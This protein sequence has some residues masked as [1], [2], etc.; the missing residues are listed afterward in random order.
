MVFTTKTYLGLISDHIPSFAFPLQIFCEISPIWIHEIQSVYLGNVPS[1]L[2][3]SFSELFW[4]MSLFLALWPNFEITTSHD[5]HGFKK[6]FSITLYCEELGSKKVAF[7]TFHSWRSVLTVK[8]VASKLVSGPPR[9]HF[10]PLVLLLTRFIHVPKCTSWS[11]MTPNNAE[12]MG[13][14][15]RKWFVLSLS[16][17]WA[18]FIA[19]NWVCLRGINCISLHLHSIQ[20]QL[21]CICGM[22]TLAFP[23]FIWV[24]C[25]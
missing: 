12:N 24:T 18:T 14:Q 23:V 20:K 19:G 2:A 25:F 21:V 9:V 6:T 3:R 17:H 7:Q 1:R 13:N 11:Q 4:C 16:C 22:Q 8:G 10:Y 5:T 15:I